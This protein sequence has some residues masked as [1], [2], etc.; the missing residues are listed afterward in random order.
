[1]YTPSPTAGERT[2]K[3]DLF[4]PTA[5]LERFISDVDRALLAGG[6]DKG[7]YFSVLIA[8]YYPTLLNQKLTRIEWKHVRQNLMK[9]DRA[10]KSR[11][12]SDAF[13]YAERKRQAVLR[14]LQRNPTIEYLMDLKSH[15]LPPPITIGCKVRALL[16]KPQYGIFD[17][18]VVG[19]DEN[20]Q[21]LYFVTF[22]KQFHGKADQYVEDS[23]LAIVEEN[24]FHETLTV[25]YKLFKQILVLEKWCAEK[26]AIL[27]RITKLRVAAECRRMN[28]VAVA[29]Q[30]HESDSEYL[31]A[32]EHIFTVDRH[33]L[34]QGTILRSMHVQSLGDSTLLDEVFPPSQQDSHIE[35]REIDGELYEVTDTSGL[36]RS[37]TDFHAPAAED[38]CTNTNS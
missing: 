19:V 18:T 37:E 36:W 38:N 34:R 6:D 8:R 25:P 7:C 3:L 33:I 28:G 14:Y 22:D 2:R 9:F 10:P 29:S 5:V 17:G 13:F 27:N 16:Y 32:I 15:V 26:K 21:Q 35:V 24:R 12:C 4:H 11:R 23:R 1:M 30:G 31:A 20:D